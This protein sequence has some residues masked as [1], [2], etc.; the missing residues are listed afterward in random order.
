[1]DELY[2]VKRPAADLARAVR[3]IAGAQSGD[4]LVRVLRSHA[5]A[6]LGSQGIAVILKDGD[7]CHYIEEDAIGAL[8]KG[9]RFPAVACISGW[10]MINRQTAV[11]PDI[12][13]DPRIP[14][15]LY[16]KTFV[17]ALAMAPVRLE[18]PLAAIGAYWDSPYTPTDWEIEALEALHVTS[19]DTETRFIYRMHT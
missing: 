15:E 19:N 6:I 11:V 4:E 1:M 18:E 10:A 3:H 12:E 13:M 7:D 5:R 9:Q 17:K 2:K 14:Q 16:S 8:W